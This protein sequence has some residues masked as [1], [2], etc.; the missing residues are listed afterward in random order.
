MVKGSLCSSVIPRSQQT[1]EQTPGTTDKLDQQP[2]AR[3]RH[4]RR[5]YRRLFKFLIT[6]LKALPPQRSNHH[7]PWD[8]VSP[9]RPH[10]EWDFAESGERQ[11]SVWNLPRK[12]ASVHPHSPTLTSLLHPILTPPSKVSMEAPT[13]HRNASAPPAP[14][15]RHMHQQGPGERCHLGPHRPAAAHRSSR[16]NQTQTEMKLRLASCSGMKCAKHRPYH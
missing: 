4:R 7:G 12:S 14:D 2:L 13:P 5:A 11:G 3:C 8:L 1:P 15:W 9:E 6:P 16:V 10:K